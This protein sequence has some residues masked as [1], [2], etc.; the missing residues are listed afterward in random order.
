[1]RKATV[2][3]RSL[4]PEFCDISK[5]DY[6]AGPDIFVLSLHVDPHG[7][8]VGVEDS[9]QSGSRWKNTRSQLLYDSIHA[10]DHELLDK[11]RRELFPA[12]RG[13]PTSFTAHLN[14]VLEDIGIGG[15]D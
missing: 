4:A 11:F 3:L 6:A 8:L 7:K 15:T 12:Y 14:K 1:M 5:L 2:T 13:K 9:E 10:F